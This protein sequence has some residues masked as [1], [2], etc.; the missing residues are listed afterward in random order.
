MLEFIEYGRKQKRHEF[1]DANL[2][3]SLLVSNLISQGRLV[4][5]EGLIRTAMGNIPHFTEWGIWSYPD[6]AGF[7]QL[8]GIYGEILLG[9][10]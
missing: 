2:A 10:A 7:A 8:V 9:H 4:E 1:I 5:A 6:L 3:L